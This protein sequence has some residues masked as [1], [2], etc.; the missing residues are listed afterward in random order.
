MIVSDKAYNN[1][2]IED[3][4]DHVEIHLRPIRKVK[5]KRP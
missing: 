5:S 1:Y 3:T 4:L 2:E